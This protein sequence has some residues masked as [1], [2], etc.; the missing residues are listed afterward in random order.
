MNRI[1]TKTDNEETG[2]TDEQR[3][4]EW[5]LRNTIERNTRAKLAERVYSLIKHTLP[6]EVQKL[7]DELNEVKY[8]IN[9]LNQL[10]WRLENEIASRIASRVKFE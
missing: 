7:T 3:R 9:A 8:R 10:R 5:R 1:T 4:R 6:A 2:E